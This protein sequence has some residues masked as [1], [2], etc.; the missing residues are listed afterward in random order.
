MD[1]QHTSLSR[2]QLR[3]KKRIRRAVNELL[4]LP[5]WIRVRR[6]LYA[7][8]MIL[9]GAAVAS[10]GYVL[11]QVPFQLAAGGISGLGIIVNHF[12]GIPVGLFFLLA[13][14]PLMV[15]GF[16]QLG[17]WPFVLS[18]ITAVLA[19]SLGADLFTTLLPPL[20]D[21]YPLTDD[22]LLAAV[23]AGILYGL[24]QG[25]IFRAGGSVG[26]T[27]IPARIL[28][29]RTG[30]P[31]SQSYMFTDLAI[32]LAAGVFFGWE[33]A[34]LAFLSLILSGMVSDF[35]LEGASQV[36]TAV[37]VTEHPEWMRWAIIS[38]LGKG[39][40][41]WSVTGGY[42]GQDRTM[43]YCTVRRSQVTDLRRLAGRIDPAAFLVIGV[44]QQAWGGVGGNSLLKG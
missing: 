34:L 40:S 1:S 17:R 20:F 5:G 4:E 12:T 35:V 2:P 27:S 28:H 36:R 6:I 41:M 43:L 23:Y 10:A 44:V 13:N 25:L 14:L 38:E 39:V 15:L 33:K 3:P 29:R 19:F 22:L 8:L 24:G 7:Q 11:F 42:T 26:G 21:P 32:I 18:T 31:M 37:I 30:F 16:Y 9:L